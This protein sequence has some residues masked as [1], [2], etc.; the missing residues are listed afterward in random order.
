[1]KKTAKKLSLAKETLRTLNDKDLTHV[2]G[3]GPTVQA[4]CH[5]RNPTQCGNTNCFTC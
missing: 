2:P 3:G 5:T 4:A 1:M